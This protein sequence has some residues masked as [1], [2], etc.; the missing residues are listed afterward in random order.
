MSARRS[1][2][3]RVGLLLI[4]LFVG[5]AE[6]QALRAAYATYRTI[7]RPDEVSRH[8]A[9]LQA[10]KPALPGHG[11]VGYVSDEP[12]EASDPASAAARQSFKRYLLT[13]YALVPIVLSRGP[14]GDLVVG[15]FTPSAPG[16]VAAPPG[17]VMV[18]DFG[19]GVVLFRRLP[20]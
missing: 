12:A 9:R 11:L 16:G 19:G 2:R 6:L 3:L 1:P 13:Q 7:E 15:D 8:E 5:L 17:F 4:G 18:Q 14:D 20:R 10:V